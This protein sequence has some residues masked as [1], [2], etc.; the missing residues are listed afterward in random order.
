MAGHVAVARLG[1][2]ADSFREALKQIGSI[3][4]LNSSERSVVIKV[5]V[6]NHKAQNHTSV[7]VLKAIIDS[8]TKAPKIYIVES[9]NYIGKGSERLQ[10]WKELFNER[11]VPFNLSEDNNLKKV[12]VADEEIGLSHLLFKPNIFVSTHILRKYE[13]GSILKNLLGLIPDAKKAR[14]HRKLEPALLDMYEA[15]GGIDLAVLDGTYL[16][17]GA[18]SDPHI[19]PDGDKSKTM[20]DIVL[21]SRDSVAVE[22]VGLALAGIEP[23]K[24]S[25]IQEAVRR[26]LGIGDLKKIRITGESFERLKEEVAKGLQALRKSRPKGPQTWGGRANRALAELIDDGY[27]KLPH[28]RTISDVMKAF[29]DKGLETE[30]KQENVRAALIRRVKNGSLQASKTLNKQ[31][32]WTE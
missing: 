23:E 18:S 6:F 28:K 16:R 2:N 25:I 1:R 14:F 13:R 22:T 27:F 32:F 3:E 12:K 21:I 20:T 26:R 9:D 10:I 8:F 31:L 5:G 11:V 7:E 19:G 29:K 15:I 30:G 17:Y 4:D 24:A